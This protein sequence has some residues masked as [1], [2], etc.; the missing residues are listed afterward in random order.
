MTALGKILVFVSV[1]LSFASL[2]VASWLTLDRRDWKKELQ[3]KKKALEA[4]YHPVNRANERRDDLVV[5]AQRGTQRKFLFEADQEKT[6][7]EARAALVDLSRENDQLANQVNTLI[8]NEAR[9]RQDLVDAREVTARELERLRQLSELVT[10]EK[11]DALGIP[12]RIAQLI[13][14]RLQADKEYER[15]FPEIANGE[16]RVE[17]LQIRNAELKRRLADLRRQAN[18]AGPAAR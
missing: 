9:S 4:L 5:E 18:P 11:P 13:Q 14:E 1:I 6:V 15:L 8:L 2:G 12:A 16:A 10:P 17:L 3:E 7:A